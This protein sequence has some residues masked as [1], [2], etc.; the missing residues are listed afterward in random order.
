MINENCAPIQCR[1]C[2]E[3]AVYHCEDGYQ[4]EECGYLLTWSFFKVSKL[5]CGCDECKKD[6]KKYF[7][8]NIA[9]QKLGQDYSDFQI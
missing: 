1:S 2:E 9:P 5:K 8:K 6:L 7:W 4:C 3:L